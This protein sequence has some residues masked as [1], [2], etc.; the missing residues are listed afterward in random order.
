MVLEA[1]GPRVVHVSVFEVHWTTF[2]PHDSSDT[3]VSASE[4]S[5]IWHCGFVQEVPHCHF[6]AL[7]Y[8]NVC[9][10]IKSPRVVWSDIVSLIFQTSSHQ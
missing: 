10:A 3:F 7:I 6:L 5:Q 8:C 9:R 2:F 1:N 4:V